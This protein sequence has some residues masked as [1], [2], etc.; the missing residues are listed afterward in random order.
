[1]LSLF[2][3]LVT[4]LANDFCFNV[5]CHLLNDKYHF[6][7][8]TRIDYTTSILVT[9]I[10]F[11]LLTM[12]WY[13][14]RIWSFELLC[15]YGNAAVSVA[16]RIRGRGNWMSCLITVFFTVFHGTYYAHLISTYEMLGLFIS[17]TL[18]ICHTTIVF[19]MSYDFVENYLVKFLNLHAEPIEE[20]IEPE[21]I[22]EDELTLDPYEHEVPLPVETEIDE[23]D[24]NEEKD[25]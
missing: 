20:T 3:S 1:M 2:P 18:N 25:D 12:P 17:L 8:D 14:F 4:F 19:D 24:P 13:F 5:A 22:E 6:F 11:A 7:R 10:C 16:S 21:S 23:H 15:I 9:G